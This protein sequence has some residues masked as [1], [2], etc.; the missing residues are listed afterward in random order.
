MDTTN[1]IN[2]PRRQQLM[3]VLK[4]IKKIQIDPVISKTTEFVVDESDISKFIVFI[5]P[6]EGLYLGLIISFELTVPIAYPAPGHPIQ[7]KCLDA[8]YHPNIYAGGRLCL[9]YDGVGNLETGYKETL[10]NLVVAINYLFVHP[11]NTGYGSSKMTDDMQMTIKKNIDQYRLRTKVDRLPKKDTDKLYK[12]KEIYSDKLNYSLIKI[13]NWDT[14]I[15]KICLNDNNKSRHYV[16]TLGGRKIM[17]LAKL[18]DVISNLIHDPRIVFDTVPNI[19]YMKDIKDQEKLFEPITPFSVTLTKF[20]RINYPDVIQWDCINNCFNSGINFEKFINVKPYN[21]TSDKNMF[22]IIM[23]NIVIRSNYKFS[24][25]C[26]KENKSYHTI[27][28]SNEKIIDGSK[29]YIMNIDQYTCS[30]NKNINDNYL[31][32][33]NLDKEDQFFNPSKPL[34]FYTTFS[35]MILGEDLVKMFTNVAYRLNP[36][37][38]NS[39]Y[40]TTSR[41]GT[42]LLT[43]DE[44]KLISIDSNDS[45]KSSNPDDY[46]DIEFAAKYLASTPEQTG[47]DLSA[48]GFLN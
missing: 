5:R 2:V 29:E 7:A 13:N 32:L 11:G 35:V 28:S 42:R 6:N 23:C 14:Y 26:Q 12:S 25:S 45:V 9:Q 30:L 22:M 20:K 24:F 39:P 43:T 17:D 16:F 47:L 34:W 33:E 40:V 21:S 38:K 3:F 31:I 46:Y 27:M 4:E 15:P 10:E 19:A 36:T 44:L 41:S 37:D 1:I 48:V 18:E 8:I